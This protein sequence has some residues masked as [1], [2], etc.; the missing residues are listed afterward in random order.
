MA[1]TKI[2]TQNVGGD[3]KTATNTIRVGNASFI[4][5]SIFDESNHL[6]EVLLASVKEKIY[7]TAGDYQYNL[8]SKG[9]D[10]L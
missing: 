8:T 2:V 9:G 4:I 1:Q 3:I 10:V 6:I 5:C 7:K